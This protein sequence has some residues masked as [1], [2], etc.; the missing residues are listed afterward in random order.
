M[1]KNDVTAVGYES[2]KPVSKQYFRNLANHMQQ[3]GVIA[4]QDL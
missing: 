3:N 1:W 4:K 2:V